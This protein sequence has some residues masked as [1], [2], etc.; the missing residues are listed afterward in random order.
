MGNDTFG[1]FTNIHRYTDTQIHRYTEYALQ[2]HRKT[3]IQNLYMYIY[4]ETQ[5]TKEND[6]Q[7]KAGVT[8][9]TCS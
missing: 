1:G 3:D 8:G 5:M 4:T 9:G 6:F 2:K 7:G